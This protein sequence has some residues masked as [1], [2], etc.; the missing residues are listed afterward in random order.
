VSGLSPRARRVI[1]RVLRAPAAL[2]RPRSR[3]LMRWLSPA[4]IVVLVHRGRRSGRIYRTPVEALVEDAERGEIVISPM[5]GE[6]ADWYRN[7]IAG[8]L[9]EARL[10]GEAHEMEWRRLSDEESELATAAYR[11]EH[12]L[13]SRLIFWMLARLHGR[14]GDRP[15][16]VAAA[17][18]MLALHR[19]ET[20]AGPR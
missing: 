9:L 19:P 4:P 6:N 17:L 20:A 7:V 18:P 3:W 10:G 15:E 2:D 13:Y 16:A 14:P 5:F 12:P 1:G 8:G 11:R